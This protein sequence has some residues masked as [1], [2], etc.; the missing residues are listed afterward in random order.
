VSNWLLEIDSLQYFGLSH[1]WTNSQEM[2]C[3]T[4]S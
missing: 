3:W 4:W 1:Q 2:T